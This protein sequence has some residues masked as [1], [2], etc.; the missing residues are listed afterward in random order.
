MMQERNR[1]KAARI[2]M[3][4]VFKRLVL[5]AIAGLSI[6]ALFAQS[7]ISEGIPEVAGDLQ[8]IEC[9]VYSF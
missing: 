9:H 4:Q 1:A 6:A 3:P 7:A 8:F 2:G 5:G